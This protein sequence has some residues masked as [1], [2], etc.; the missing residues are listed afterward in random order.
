MVRRGFHK[1]SGIPVA[2]KVSKI[3]NHFKSYERFKSLSLIQQRALIRKFA[4]LSTA[5]VCKS[6][7][8]VLFS[9]LKCCTDLLLL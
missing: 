4:L 7:K 1:A 6:S 9:Q 5:F 2:I 3:S 8:T